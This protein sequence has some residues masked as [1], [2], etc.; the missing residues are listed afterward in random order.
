MTTK[1]TDF[2]I[3]FDRIDPATEVFAEADDFA[4]IIDAD[5]SLRARIA[6]LL[7]ERIAEHNVLVALRTAAGLTQQ[8]VAEAWGRAQ[9]HVSRAERGELANLPLRSLAAYVDALGGSMR[10]VFELH[11][12][13]VEMACSA[14][15]SLSVEP[16]PGGR[17]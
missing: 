14:S 13:R 9:P 16:T 4:T 2:V 11:G 5:G 3:D 7:D 17:R 1:K 8:E 15:G 12:A 10:V 6:E